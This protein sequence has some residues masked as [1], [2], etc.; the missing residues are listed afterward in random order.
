MLMVK[1]R[2]PHENPDRRADGDRGSASDRRRNVANDMSNPSRGSAASTVTPAP[3]E[4]FVRGQL[5][6]DRFEILR[7][8][9]A[10]GMGE[11]YEAED[12]ELHDR[13]ALKTVRLGGSLSE[14][15]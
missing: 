11:V 5:V 2:S 15:A 1:P 10:G 9:A 12:L 13:V 3:P 14:T 4:S 6:A 7:F 8:I